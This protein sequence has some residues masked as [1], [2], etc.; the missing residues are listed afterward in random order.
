MTFRALGQVLLPAILVFVS[1]NTVAQPVPTDAA[2][3][4]AA[5]DGRTRVTV[6][7]QS[8][9]FATAVP[10]DTTGN[11]FLLPIAQFVKVQSLDLRNGSDRTVRV[12]R[13]ELSTRA[14]ETG[15]DGPFGR[16]SSPDVD[17]GANANGTVTIEVTPEM[18]SPGGTARITFTLKDNFPT[19]PGS[20]RGETRIQV[21]G[22]DPLVVPTSVT[23]RRAPLYALVTLIA[24]VL[25]GRVAAQLGLKIPKREEGSPKAWKRAL[26]L[27]VGDEGTKADKRLIGAILLLTFSAEH[28][29]VV[30][31]QKDLTWGVNAFWDYVTLFANGLAFGA[32][33]AAFTQPESDPP[34]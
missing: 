13:V 1:A 20:M 16:W 22:A 29:Y 28:F 2:T 10:G 15:T 21:D 26:R 17:A 30:V 6:Q 14:E 25:L 8:L 9:S 19:V 23:A 24:A 18:V 12:R 5:E 33:H 4:R 3:P 34:K 32:A 27:V 31:I 7:P 11:M